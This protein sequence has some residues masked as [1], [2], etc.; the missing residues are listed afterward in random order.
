MTAA[1]ITLPRA[2]STVLAAVD[3]AIAIEVLRELHRVCLGMDID[4]Q[5]VRPT[6]AEYQAVM[7]RAAEALR[8]YPLTER[9]TGAHT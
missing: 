5:D 1:R 2:S 3:A 8:A 9:I 4:N 6:E 7:A